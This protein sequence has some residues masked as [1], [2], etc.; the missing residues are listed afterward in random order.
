MDTLVENIVQRIAEAVQ[1]RKVILFGS[2]ARGDAHPDSDVDL[3]IIYDGDLPKRELKLKVRRLFSRPEFS[4]DLF[5]LNPDEYE[6]Q[7]KVV[8]T[9]GRVASMEGVVYYG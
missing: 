8:S 1:P 5:V 6:R 2:R 3:L 9:V 4:M 7:K